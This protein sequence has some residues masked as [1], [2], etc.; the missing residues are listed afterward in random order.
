[1]ITITENAELRVNELITT[2]AEK[3]NM[4]PQGLYLRIYIAGAGPAGLNH[5]MALTTEI[6][7]DDVVIEKGDFKILIDKMSEQYLNGAEVDYVTHELGSNFKIINP[8]QIEA[9]GC[10]GCSGDSGCC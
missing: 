1:M 3:K 2:N 8:N 6:R 10:G 4:D 7:D 5:G 9:A